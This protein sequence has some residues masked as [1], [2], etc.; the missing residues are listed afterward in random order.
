MNYKA[1]V[2]I[3]AMTSL[4]IVQTCDKHSYRQFNNKREGFITNIMSVRYG[5]REGPYES[6]IDQYLIKGTLKS[7]GI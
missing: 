1:L 3:N 7:V 6:N 4:R 2:I 5:V